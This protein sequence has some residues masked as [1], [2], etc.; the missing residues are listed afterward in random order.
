MANSDP[1]LPSKSTM[2]IG[3]IAQGRA[4][5]EAVM[6][7]IAGNINAIS[8]SAYN[9]ME[10]LMNGYVANM[11]NN[12]DNGWG[13]VRRLTADVNI[14]EY[15]LSLAKSGSGS[16]CNFNAAVYDETGA[17][18]NNLFSSAISISGNSG[19]NVVVGRDNEAVSTFEV[20]AGGHSINYGTL[21]LT[22]L[23]KGWVIQ[24]NIGGGKN[25][26]KNLL[27]NLKLKEV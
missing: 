16:S 17:F 4:N 23:L 3:D 10:F 19:N 13:G 14:S 6:A 5:S 27:F 11:T 18:V 12:A 1:V 24:S 9:N 21:N 8:S 2:L 26:A 20:N 22:T 7:K 15:Y 25:G